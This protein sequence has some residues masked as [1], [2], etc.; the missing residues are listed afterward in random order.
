MAK[1]GK[2]NSNPARSGPSQNLGANNELKYTTENW[3]G[4]NPMETD[5]GIA[6]YNSTLLELD[7]ITDTIGPILEK[8]TS[9]R[10]PSPLGH[11]RQL[12]K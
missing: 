12:K 5:P 10:V 9:K 4:F 3:G 1:R 11:S 8:I 6:S 7:P 2:Y